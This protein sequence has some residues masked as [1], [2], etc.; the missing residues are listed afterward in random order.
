MN[1]NFDEIVNRNNTNCVKHDGLKNFLKVE[2]A[3]PMWV[4]DMDFKSPPCIADALKKRV[5]HGVFGYTFR[6]DAFFDSIINWMQK[7]HQWNIEKDWIS[8]SPGVVAGFTLAIEQFTNPGDKI[9]VQPPVYFPFFQSVDDTKRTTV[10]NPLKL[11]DGRFTFDFDDL[12]AKIDDKT[13][14]LLL[15]NPHNPC[16]S[17]W[18]KDELLKLQAICQKH[19]ILVVSDEIHADIIYAPAKHIPYASISESAAMNSITVM[20]HS[21]TFNVAGLTTSFVICKN[22]ELLKKYNKGLQI[23]HL[24]MGNIFGNEALVAAYNQGEPWLEELLDYLKNNVAVVDSF[25]KKQLPQ[26]KL[27]KPESTFLLWLDCRALNLSA[28]EL[29]NLFL[30]DAKVAVN[31]G[32]MFGPGGEGFVRLN[33]G[34]PRSVLEKA[35]NQMREAINNKG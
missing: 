20:S 1:F 8:F 33:I 7:R 17:V 31:E 15:C 3:L 4:A 22:Q 27:I 21:K 5:E 6:S 32:S 34:C 28:K 19:N 16:G 24:H 9:I 12:E 35:L 10:Y 25:V 2:D 18:T 11:V 29:G 26:I 30:H 23:P 13:K 14:M